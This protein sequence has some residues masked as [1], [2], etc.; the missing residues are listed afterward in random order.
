[1]GY[2]SFILGSIG[3]CRNLHLFKEHPQPPRFAS[4]YDITV[5]SDCDIDNAEVC[6]ECCQDLETGRQEMA[7]GGKVVCLGSNK[8]KVNKVHVFVNL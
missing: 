6:I 1:M 5:L 7:L 4:S 2:L 3:I 8:L